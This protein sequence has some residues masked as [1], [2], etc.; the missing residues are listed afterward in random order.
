MSAGRNLTAAWAAVTAEDIE[1]GAI[2]YPTYR[3]RI[4][5]LAKIHGFPVS[6]ACGAF[7]ALSPRAKIVANFR[8]LRT[9]MIAVREG[10]GAADIRVSTYDKGKFAALA[11]LRGEADF[12]DICKGPKITAFRHNLLF[13]DTSPR[14]TIDGHMIGIMAGKSLSMD[15]ALLH[16]RK[17]YGGSDEARYQRLEKQFLRWWSRE[18]NARRLLPLTVQAILWHAK[19]RHDRGELVLGHG[20]PE[21]DEIN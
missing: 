9:C 12:A 3:K 11:I 2:L 5:E 6:A 16:D 15:A 17:R 21:I 10:A 8:S 4:A 1:F 20:V 13:P 19:R 14:V 18:P 7:A